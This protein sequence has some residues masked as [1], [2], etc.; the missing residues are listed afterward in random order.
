MSDF[1]S[2][3]DTA[4]L[5][6]IQKKEVIKMDLMRQF[7]EWYGSDGLK[8]YMRVI[9]G[10]L[11]DFQKMV[12]KAPAGEMVRETYKLED[13]KGSLILTWNGKSTA[14]ECTDGV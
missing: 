12:K 3:K 1:T 14:I 7:T 10:I 5:N 2:C 4:N 8:T 6:I 11:A 9:P 13:G